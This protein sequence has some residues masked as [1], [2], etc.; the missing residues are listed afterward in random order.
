MSSSRVLVVALVLC[1]VALFL[2][3]GVHPLAAAPAEVPLPAPS[4]ADLAL[5]ITLSIPAPEVGQEVDINVDI[6]NRGTA[7][8]RD[9]C[10]YLYVDPI[11]RPPTLRTAD[12]S[13]TCNH[14]DLPAGW[15]LGWTEDYTFR[16]PGTHRVYAWVDRE[17]RVSESNKDNNLIYVDVVVGG[18][19]ACP[20]D[21]YEPDNSCGKAIPTAADGTHTRHTLCT[22]G[23]QDW[24]RFEAVQGLVY[25]VKTSDVG[26]D[27][28]TILDLYDNCN[29]DPIQNGEPTLGGGASLRFMAA[30]TAP[31]YVR[32][33]H[34]DDTYGNDTHYDLSVSGVCQGDAYEPDDTCLTARA[35]EMSGAQDHLFCTQG[36]HD[37]L[38]FDARAG[39][40]YHFGLD[41]IGPDA[42]PRL[43]LYSACDTYP[44]VEKGIGESLDWQPKK[45]GIYYLRVGDAVASSYGAAA[46]YR[47]HLQ[48]SGDGGDPGEPT[49]PQGRLL[50][51]DGTP[52][53]GNLAPGDEDWY[54]FN[55]AAGKS[56]RF[57]TFDLGP[58][59]DTVLCLYGA[60]RTT[61][62]V[63]DD[64]SG[65]GLGSRLGWQAP[66]AGRY[67][68]RVRAYRQ[69]V[70]GALA[71]YSMAAW[72]DAALCDADAAE[73]DNA[74]YLAP[75]IE[76]DGVWQHRT[77]C[78]EGDPDWVRFRALAG[79]AYAIET[80]H[81]GADADTVLALYD[82]DGQTPLWGN[83]D[84]GSGRASGLLWRFQ[85]EGVYYLKVEPFALGVSG[86]GSEYDLR[87]LP[88]ALEP[89]PTATPL[90]S[91]QPTATPTA[92]PTLTPT[93]KPTVGGSP[94]PTPFPS[95]HTL[96]LT[97]RARLATFFDEESARKVMAALGRLA[98]HE[99]VAGVVV[100]VSED[101][102]VNAAYAAWTAESGSIA[103]A[104]QV[105]DA[106]R[107]IVVRHMLR[108]PQLEYIVLVGDDRIIPYRRVADRPDILGFHESDYKDID[109]STTVGAALKAD[110]TLSDDFYADKE[111]GTWD[112]EPLYLPDYAIGRLVETPADITG[113]IDGFLARPSVRLER[114]MV[115]GYDSTLEDGAR[116]VC[117]RLGKAVETAGMDC[118]M[119]GGG[120]G[121]AELQAKQLWVAPRY[122]VQGLATGAGHY[123]ENSPAG[124]RTLAQTIA[125]ANVNL[126]GALVWNV[127]RYAGLSM[128]ASNPVLAMDLP[129]AFAGKRANYVGNTGRTIVGSEAVLLSE[130]LMSLF[131]EELAVGSKTPIGRAWQQAKHRYYLLAGTF[132]EGDRKILHM[133][134]FYG[135]PMATLLHS[136]P[137]PGEP[138]PNV[139]AGFGDASVGAAGSQTAG[140]GEASQSQA[141]L[142]VTLADSFR[143]F[144]GHSASSGSYYSLD[145]F[146]TLA[147]NVP[148]QPLF[149]AD[150][151]GWRR[152]PPRGVVWTSGVYT[153]VAS[154]APLRPQAVAM[155]EAG[156]MAQALP[157]GAAG[158]SQEA[159]SSGK[160]ATLGGQYGEVFNLV[161]GQYDD[162]T[163]TQR[164]YDDMTFDVYFGSSPD[165]TP[166]EVTLASARREGNAIRVKVEA[167]D[168][169]GVRRVV[170]TYTTG[171]GWFTSQ[172]L[173]YDP[174]SRKWLGSVP[175][176]GGLR[177]LLSVVDGAGNVADLN[178]KGRF[179]ALPST[180][181]LYLPVLLR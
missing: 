113:L 5:R 177:W 25:T 119:I 168:P 58:A 90:S 176:Q 141:T 89:T 11:D 22:Q 153:D 159:S 133:A 164:L 160:P 1:C 55:A 18:T 4:A 107:S 158:N 98:G 131:A 178:N 109:A 64:D 15:D 166:P 105:A 88:S 49:D 20:G 139:N 45:S 31:H 142:R 112:G 61:P 76:A 172:D 63:C 78:P 148:V 29:E 87:I 102:V 47:L 21:T 127:G 43:A 26:A 143:T 10:T 140:E 39:Q 67:Y 116:E 157:A 84:A 130:R 51:T 82:V 34:H 27:A 32:V 65:E 66:A 30:V 95:A 54:Y 38:R 42:Q 60:D 103:K 149:F 94:T 175:V 72:L 181:T 62:L 111:L 79:Q 128:V 81:L 35:A 85:R 174:L 162:A 120:W 53:L 74:H 110:Q 167:D 3:G 68:L 71:S 169:S 117:S 156:Q 17:G 106:V 9:F 101:A 59:A 33:K 99:A 73:P 138:F 104:N 121:A 56:Y 97:N 92:T 70:G 41:N 154:F 2:T 12:T 152:G 115:A 50:P 118:T 124:Q 146:A 179:F 16:T 151:D 93:P 144:E 150:T 129:Q 14:T 6:L 19:A 136:G 23:D 8:A 86:R 147:P 114:I 145:D 37:W 13:S 108:S 96:I 91:G 122:D 80:A 180:S 7:S 40:Q 48:A 173:Q 77:S 126:Q 155:D 170:L 28:D 123:Y 161:M 75:L 125:D 46:N 36:D 132:T 83:D 171:A 163:G 165:R 44:L 57:E 100:D 134:T 135:L 24:I 52:Q 137:L 69:E